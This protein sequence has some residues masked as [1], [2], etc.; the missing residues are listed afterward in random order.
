MA[1]EDAQFHYSPVPCSP[2]DPSDG[3]TPQ[4]GPGSPPRTKPISFTPHLPQ[5]LTNPGLQATHHACAVVA[6]P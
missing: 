2:P 6:L 5:Q 3:R 4:S 1:H